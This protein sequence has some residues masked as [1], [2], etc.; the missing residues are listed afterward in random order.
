MTMNPVGGQG[1]NLRGAFVKLRMLRHVAS[2][3][4]C[5]RRSPAQVVDGPARRRRAIECCSLG[6]SRLPSFHAIDT[7]SN[8]IPRCRGEASE[9]V[10]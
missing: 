9:H 7:N 1:T 5:L 2:G 10:P 8:R 4:R 6:T 3:V